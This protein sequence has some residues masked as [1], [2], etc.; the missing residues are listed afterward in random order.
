MNIDLTGAMGLDI[1][2]SRMGDI[3]DAKLAER[4]GPAGTPPKAKRRIKPATTHDN[5]RVL[6]VPDL[7]VPYNHPDAFSFLVAVR[8]WLKPTRVICTGDE[9]D[10]H[11]MSF[12]TSD[13]DLDSAGPELEKSRAGM[14]ELE[15]HFK[16]LDLVT[17]NH[18]SL[19]RRK[20]YEHGIPE[21]LITHYRHTLFGETEDDGTVEYPEDRGA[22]WWWHDELVIDLPDG[23]HAVMRHTWG[24]NLKLMAQRNGCC[25]IQGHHHGLLDVQHAQ[26][27]RQRIWSLTAGC[28]VDP[29]CPAMAYG[30]GNAVQPMIGCAAIIDSEP[31]AIPM[32]LDRRGRWT[33]RL[34]VV[35]T[36]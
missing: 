30:R 34:P 4:F 7:H 33:G 35:P 32:P 3:I 27:A 6:V 25:L 16:Q 21:R 5:S 9:V 11:A 2:I 28:L 36:A 17:S 23:R 29:E 8:D 31:C 18:G 20:A 24:A 13:P 26:L 10:N 14:A 22:G 19:S 1:M 15:R 12:H